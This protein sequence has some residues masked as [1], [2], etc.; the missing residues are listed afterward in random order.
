[1]K[2]GYGI[3]LLTMIPMREN[4][5]EKSQLVNQLLFGEYYLV[6]EEK[7]DWILIKTMLDNYTGWIDKKMHAALDE[8]LFSQWHES[9]KHIIQSVFEA[10]LINETD[11]YSVKLCP[12]CLTPQKFHNN[13]CMIGGK[14]F[15]LTKTIITSDKIEMETL[16]KG[17][18]GVPYLWG[19]KTPYGMD[20]SGF[21]QILYRKKHL[22]FPRD[23][24]QQISVGIPVNALEE[25]LKGDLAFFGKNMDDIT[26]VGL[27]LE[28][29]QIIHASG[30]VRIDRLD[31]KGIF[32]EETKQHTHKLQAIRRI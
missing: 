5:S 32:N 23:A 1:M 3:S 11:G 27:I 4:P 7:P 17:L 24:S 26:H 28:N 19:G 21:T 30:R 9:E 8:L 12:G 14:T 15:N 13:R 20:C 18:L 25:A 2:D 29:K 16:A 6:V 10:D 31:E 22:D